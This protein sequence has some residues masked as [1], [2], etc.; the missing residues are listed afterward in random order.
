MAGSCPG[1]DHQDS[2][3]LLRRAALNS[4]ILQPVLVLG[5]VESHEVSMGPL[6]KLVQVPLDGI[7]SLMCVS[8]DSLEKVLCHWTIIERSKCLN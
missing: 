3:V 8:N 1:S 7:Q 4:F 2:Q 5:V 6:L